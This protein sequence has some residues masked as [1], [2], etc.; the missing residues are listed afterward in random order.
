MDQLHQ[1]MVETFDAP[2][3]GRFIT[4]SEHGEDEMDFGR[5]YL[6]IERSDDLLIV[7]ITANNTR[8]IAQKKSL[9][10]R[11][12]ERLSDDP[13]IRPEDIFINIVDVPTENWS[14]GLGEAQYA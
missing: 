6:G 8:S 9:Y 11:I 2:V 13:G 10:K 1:A 3:D 12:A 14:F 5:S 7:Q 4:L